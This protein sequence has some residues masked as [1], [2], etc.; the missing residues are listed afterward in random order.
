MQKTTLR[1]KESN[2]LPGTAA[3]PKSGFREQMP[4][5]KEPNAGVPAFLR[6]SSLTP[7][8][9]P[10]ILQRQTDEEEDRLLQRLPE[11]EAEIEQNTDEIPV[12][13][14]PVARRNATAIFGNGTPANPGMTLA[15]FNRYTRRQEEWFVEPSLS[16]TDQADLW[17]LVR[18]IAEGGYILAGAGDLPISSLRAVNDANW[19]NLAA[20]GRA[21]YS[22]GNTVRIL[23]ASLPG[24]TMAQRIALGS[25]LIGLEAIIPAAVLKLTVSE[26]QLLDV[27]SG[28]LLPALSFYWLTFQ[29]HLQEVYTPAAG[30]RGLEFQRILDLLNGPGILPFIALLGRIRN[31]HR[32]S[33]PTLTKLMT[34]FA[35]TSRSRPVHLLLVS[36]HD[37]PGS[38]RANIPLVENL[39]VNSPNNVLVLEGQASLAGIT[40]QIPVIAG[41]YGQADAGGT[42]RI[43]Q[44][45]ICGHG[46][47]R[48]IELAGTGAPIV[49]PTAVTY[50]TDSLDLDANNVAAT[51]LIDTLTRH[52][53]PATAR[54]VYTGCLEGSTAVPA[55]PPAASISGYFN[56]LACQN[57]VAYTEAR[58]KAQGLSPGFARG[59]RA[60]AGTPAVF[61][62]AA[63]NLAVQYP[64]DPDAHGTALA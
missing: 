33:V 1:K 63:G 22:G 20:F 17:D 28:G 14:T 6:F 57:L 59:M 50:P 45:M 27:R 37:A 40:A 26:A 60:V 47:T 43:G 30:A 35:D 8:V 53:D 7:Q 23:P 52:L 25:T 54:I 4:A 32:F 44:A 12:A 31:L 11:D 16:A 5:A 15:G 56:N 39:V 42:F 41:T 62:D 13:P 10:R 24:Y 58:G 61:M 36:G 18:R 38:F 51:A 49:S 34:N 3:C 46:E 29:P 9:N 48:M 2:K 19:T 55:N 21:C 64:F